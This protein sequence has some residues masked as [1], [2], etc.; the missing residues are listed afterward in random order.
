MVTSLERRLTEQKNLRQILNKP[1]GMFAGENEGE[2]YSLR[3][4][5][6]LRWGNDYIRYRLAHCALTSTYI[7]L[8]H[9]SLLL[10]D[11]QT[12]RLTELENVAQLLDFMH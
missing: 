7:M 12:D 11:S 1:K 6:L 4:N 10:A 5:F 3:A 2:Q 9:L 8:D